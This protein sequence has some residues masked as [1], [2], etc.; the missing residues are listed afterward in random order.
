[1]EGAADLMAE[2]GHHFTHQLLPAV[3]HFP[4]LVHAWCGAEIRWHACHV[5]A[6][7]VALRLTAGAFWELCRFLLRC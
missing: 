3:T 5:A 2:D 1:M 7:R 4:P 6:A